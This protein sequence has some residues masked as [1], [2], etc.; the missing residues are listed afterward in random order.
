MTSSSFST[1]LLSPVRLAFQSYEDR[2]LTSR[3]FHDTPCLCCLG[4]RLEASAA[5][6]S[7]DARETRARDGRFL[8]HATADSYSVDTG[9]SMRPPTISLFKVEHHMVAF[10]SGRF[11]MLFFPSRY[12]FL[13]VFQCSF[14]LIVL[15]AVSR[16]CL[17]AS[18]GTDYSVLSSHN[19]RPGHDDCSRCYPYR[20]YVG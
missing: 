2:A 4:T 17:D 10:L 13:Q 6:Y 1:T 20:P 12:R 14:E 3:S 16:L 18:L 7:F 15:L 5:C 19:G 11:R 9:H 8:L